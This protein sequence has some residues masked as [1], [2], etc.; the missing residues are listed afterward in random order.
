MTKQELEEK[1]GHLKGQFLIKKKRLNLN[2]GMKDI[3][4]KIEGIEEFNDWLE[5]YNETLNSFCYFHYT[6]YF[7]L[8]PDTAKLAMIQEWLREDRDLCVIV[9]SVFGQKSFFWCINDTHIDENES[10]TYN[11]SLSEGIKKAIEIL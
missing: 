8:M 4:E 7:D 9:D 6:T 3:I 1:Y 5:N 11:E 10:P 2:K